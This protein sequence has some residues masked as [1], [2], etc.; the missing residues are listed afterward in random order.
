VYLPFLFHMLTQ[1]QIF[2]KLLLL[3]YNVLGKRHKVTVIAIANVIDLLI[4]V[5]GSV[6]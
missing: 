3:E 4:P 5:K 2:Q 1:V 6:K